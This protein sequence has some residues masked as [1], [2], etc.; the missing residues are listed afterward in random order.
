M[1]ILF[2]YLYRKKINEA[3]HRL[4]FIHKIIREQDKNIDKFAEENEILDTL[5]IKK[6]KLLI[7]YDRTLGSGACS[8]VYRG[9]L[10]GIAPL[11]KIKGEEHYLRRRVIARKNFLL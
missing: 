2:Y 3:R 10:S 5:Y 7:Y 6:E 4:D 9:F 8:T 1:L 11:I